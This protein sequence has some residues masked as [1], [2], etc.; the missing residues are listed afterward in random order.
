MD[1]QENNLPART[2]DLFGGDPPQIRPGDFGIGDRGLST[3]AIVLLTDA[4]IRTF[5]QLVDGIEDGKSLSKIIFPPSEKSIS[6]NRPF[7]DEV[8]ALIKKS[9]RESGLVDPNTDWEKYYDMNVFSDK[10]RSALVPVGVVSL[11]QLGYYY[12][13]DHLKRF[14]AGH[15]IRTLVQRELLGFFQNTHP[16]I[17]PTAGD[18]RRAAGG[19]SLGS[20][21][22]ESSAKEKL[23]KQLELLE[24]LASAEESTD[25]PPVAIDGFCTKR[26]CVSF[27]KC[28]NL[29]RLISY[30]EFVIADA[31]DVL[32]GKNAADCE[33]RA[34]P[35]NVDFDEFPACAE[36]NVAEAKRLD[37][38]VANLLRFITKVK[39]R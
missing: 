1:S 7:F 36:S 23:T 18:D 32:N 22:D 27:P 12:K 16:N 28:E 10:V 24:G 25:A 33:I 26:S 8:A 13:K 38:I 3:A 17:R 5:F 34:R 35:P 21:G 2:P 4:N 14:I 37:A 31:R 6:K 11:N 20:A 19:E 30:Y 9:M 29:C 39:Y 15:R